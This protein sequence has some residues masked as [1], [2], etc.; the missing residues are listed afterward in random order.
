MCAREVSGDDE[1]PQEITAE[2]QDR[3]ETSATVEA[4]AKDNLERAEA[5]VDRLTQ[6]LE[7]AQGQ[8]R[9]AQSAA[10]LP[11]RLAAQENVLRL[12]GALQRI[13]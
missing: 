11:A 10:D 12:E 1:E 13:P 8:L 5:D 6:Q 3:L 2:A 7:A 9:R 4:A